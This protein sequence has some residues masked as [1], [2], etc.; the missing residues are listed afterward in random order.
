MQVGVDV[1]EERER[2]RQEG[3][4]KGKDKGQG[5]RVDSSVLEEKNK[6]GRS[7]MRPGSGGPGGPNSDKGDT[8]T[9]YTLDTQQDSGPLPAPLGPPLSLSSVN[10]PVKKDPRSRPPA[11][12][13]HGLTVVLGSQIQLLLQS[14]HAH[15]AE[16][17]QQQQMAYKRARKDVLLVQSL[18]QQ[19]AQRLWPSCRV[20]ITGSQATGLALKVSDCWICLTLKSLNAFSLV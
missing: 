13:L 19:S 10:I 8:H 14:L 6:G 20:E 12:P 4:E 9:S 16:Q 2:R 3:E 11:P 15:C 5:Q 17:F 18:V 1:E 7:H